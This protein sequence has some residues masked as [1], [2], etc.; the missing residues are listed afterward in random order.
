VC[1]AC[2]YKGCRVKTKKTPKS[3]KCNKSNCGKGQ[4][5]L[6]GTIFAKSRMPLHQLLYISVFWLFESP[7]KIAKTQISCSAKT[8]SD[9]FKV[10]RQMI[11]KI[12][13]LD[14]ELVPGT[15]NTIDEGMAV[16]MWRR[17][18]A[19]NLWGAFVEALKDSVAPYCPVV[20]VGIGSPGEEQKISEYF[21][22]Q[23]FGQPCHGT[24]NVD[25]D[26][27]A[28]AAS[29]WT[30]AQQEQQKKPKKGQQQKAKQPKQP[31]GQKRPHSLL[32]FGEVMN[33]GI[34]QPQPKKQNADGKRPKRNKSIPSF[35]DVCCKIPSEEKAIEFL[36]LEGIFTHPKDMTCSHCGYKGFRARGKKTLKSIKCNRCS[37]GSS[38]MKGTFFE[39][40]K[41]PLQQVIYMAVFWLSF[42]P[43]ATVIAQLRCSSATVT[44]ISN[45]FRRLIKRYLEDM[46]GGNSISHS[47][48]NVARLKQHIPKFARK[49]L[50]DEHLC[51]AMWREMNR[52]N[53]WEAFLVVL[54][55]VKNVGAG[56]EPWVDTKNGKACCKYH[57]RLYEKEKQ[58]PPKQHASQRAVEQQDWV[59]KEG[60]IHV[61]GK[62]WHPYLEQ[63]EPEISVPV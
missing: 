1:N 27:A 18:N 50:R 30:E 28:V 15:M 52:G 3:L 38:L 53:I 9:F 2:G 45:K 62:V 31:Q 14:N 36:T 11:M 60:I 61:A 43:A 54:Q 8:V 22:R 7:T 40:M 16:S 32:T 5:L 46:Q 34:H 57:Q 33:D 6:R 58:Q 20:D 59:A 48:E 41:A 37:K 26:A 24:A 44:D 19:T 35:M 63:Q 39:G 42:S 23:Q 10:F 55:T 51:V 25:D 12:V 4:S 17:R 13:L 21:P 56:N 47:V 29:V 49:E